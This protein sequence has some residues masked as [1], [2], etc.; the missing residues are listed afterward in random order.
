[1]VQNVDAILHRNDQPHKIVYVCVLAALRDQNWII[2]STFYC[3]LTLPMD[4]TMLD[5]CVLWQNTI[6]NTANIL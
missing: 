6:G 1:M 3:I 2:D 4:E 5:L